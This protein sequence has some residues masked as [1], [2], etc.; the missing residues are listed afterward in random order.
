MKPN[1]SW[2]R[3]VG[4][5]AG[6][7]L[8]SSSVCAF[9]ARAGELV[10][11]ALRL[12]V[13]ID[14]HE[15]AVE[16]D[17]FS[18]RA[19]DY[20]VILRSGTGSAQ[21]VTPLSESNYRG[22]VSGWE[23]SRVSA[24]VRD[25]RMNGWIQAGSRTYRLDPG[26]AGVQHALPIESKA[27]CGMFSEPSWGWP[28]DSPADLQGGG[29]SPT[30]YCELAVEVDYW[31]YY[32][33]GNQSYQATVDVVESLVSSA[34]ALFG[35]TFDVEFSLGT[36]IVHT[37]EASS[38]YDL[39][40]TSYT[41]SSLL[42][43]VEQVW[44]SQHTDIH[45]DVALLLQP[46]QLDA[47][48]T[49]RSG[50]VCCDNAYLWSIPAPI[51]FSHELGHVLGAV[52][53]CDG[54]PDCGLMCSNTTSSCDATMTFGSASIALINNFLANVQCLETAI[55]AQPAVV[56]SIDPPGVQVF[57]PGTF[58]LRGSGLD[59][60][61]RVIVDD[62]TLVSELGPCADYEV[63]SDVLVE[64][65]SPQASSLG[66][67]SVE[68]RNAAGLSVSTT[69]DFVPTSPPA[70]A[71]PGTIPPGNH[72]AWTYGSLPDTNTYLLTAVND[73]STTDMGGFPVLANAASNLLPA[74]DDMGLGGY[75]RKIPSALNGDWLHSQILTYDLQGVFVGASNIRSTHVHN[76]GGCNLGGCGD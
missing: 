32:Y 13:V 69:F 60:I 28:G 25:G 56:T 42:N 66:P 7:F 43:K 5:A 53:H 27:S 11:H 54:D 67:V 23:E 2:T 26:G 18:V 70:L 37:T 15:T 36:V 6:I 68:V 55:P 39:G 8:A 12:P 57:A 22:R 61:S 45:R 29:G 58:E 9:Q 16:L 59:D 38:P 14:G 19:D 21:S 76:T 64:V 35:A 63:I 73:D 20:R 72:L 41:G 40:T 4:V 44:D 65:E 62:G 48:G 30:R 34:S 71:C 10:T 50:T 1:P 3:S 46:F 75:S 17:P 33:E 47:A 74:L 52:G 49:A 31:S 51:E 24:T